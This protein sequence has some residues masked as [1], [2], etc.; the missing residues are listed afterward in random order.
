M[1]I[2]ILAEFTIA[3]TVAILV[4]QPSK[5]HEGAKFDVNA[6]VS[7]TWAEV[8]LCLLFTAKASSFSERLFADSCLFQPKCDHACCAL[9]WRW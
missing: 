3:I 2:I 8:T 5:F 6:S 9:N 1:C 7:G 4:P